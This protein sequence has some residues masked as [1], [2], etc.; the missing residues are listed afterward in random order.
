MAAE[1]HIKRMDNEPIYLVDAA[2]REGMSG[3][4]VYLYSQGVAQLEDGSFAIHDGPVA[5]MIGVYAGR[6]GNELDM[7]LGR[8]WTREVLDEM[9][10]NPVPGAHYLCR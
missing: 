7:Q 9:C 6:V 3:S 8:V 1:P 4:P 2:T 10:G 5:K